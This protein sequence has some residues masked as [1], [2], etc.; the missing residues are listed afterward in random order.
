MQD[1][2]WNLFLATGSIGVYMAYKDLVSKIGLTTQDEERKVPL[3][4]GDN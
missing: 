3:R 4:N 1:R 2:V